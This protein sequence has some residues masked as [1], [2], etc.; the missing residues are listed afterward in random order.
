MRKKQTQR[1]QKKV[2]KIRTELVKWRKEKINETTGRFVGKNSKID[3]SLYILN[4]K[5]E[6]Q[7]E[8]PK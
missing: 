8:N 2:I 4:K 7:N 3:K 1:K 5:K 6:T